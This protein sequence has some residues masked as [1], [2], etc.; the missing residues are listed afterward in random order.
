MG[1]PEGSASR[2]LLP[3]LAE[4]PGHLLWR[5]AARVTVELSATLPPGVDI[6]AYA[7]LL[8]LAGGVTRSQQSI[9]GTI[10]VSRTTMVRVAA[11]LTEQGLVER[12]RNPEDRR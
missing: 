8:S 9:A 7:A 5:A 4:A 6:H 1:L 12:V 2:E 10:D 11:D 3:A